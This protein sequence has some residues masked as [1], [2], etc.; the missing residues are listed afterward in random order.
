MERGGGSARQGGRGSE[1]VRHA[2]KPQDRGAALGV[3]GELDGELEHDREE[4]QAGPA[5]HGQDHVERD[6]VVGL[7]WRQTG[8]HQRGM[9]AEG[10]KLRTL[11]DERQPARGH[12]GHRDLGGEGEMVGQ[13][14]V[15]QRGGDRRADE[16]DEKQDSTHKACRV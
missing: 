10:K 13:D 12:D 9:L 4:G 11:P 15:K 1:G 5:E 2:R 6:V 16:T 14:A 7:D 8:E 3:P